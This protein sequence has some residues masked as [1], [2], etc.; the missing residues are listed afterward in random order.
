METE[1]INYWGFLQDKWNPQFFC[2]LRHKELASSRFFTS[3]KYK[4]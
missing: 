1:K 4:N 3:K 2:E